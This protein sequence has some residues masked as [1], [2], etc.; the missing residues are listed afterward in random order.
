MQPSKLTVSEGEALSKALTSVRDN[1]IQLH[2]NAP[3]ADQVL[4]GDRLDSVN[5]AIRD[6]REALGVAAGRKA[7][8]EMPELRAHAELM[9]GQGRD[10]VDLVFGER[11][12]G[13]LFVLECK[14][15]T[16]AGRGDRIAQ[17]ENGTLVRAQQGTREY[18]MSVSQAMQGAGKNGK[19]REVGAAIQRGLVTSVPEIR[20]F[21][22]RQEFNRDGTLGAIKYIEYSMKRN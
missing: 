1:L 11:Q 22:V 10:T 13:P 5:T 18:L 21:I 7:A 6:L 15:R 3:L 17:S 16:Q 9:E 2:E 12:N 8:Q 4:I 20:Y 19:T 14:G